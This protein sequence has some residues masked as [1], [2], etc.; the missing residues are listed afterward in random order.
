MLT[1]KQVKDVVQEQAD[2]TETMQRL[3]H[4]YYKDA[5][6]GTSNMD[7]IAFLGWWAINEKY[8]GEDEMPMTDE[9]GQ[10][11]VDPATG[12][13]QMQRVMVDPTRWPRALN[14]SEGG[15][16]DLA[17]YNKLMAQITGVWDG[18]LG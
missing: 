2:I 1:Q 13:P 9:M 4:E 17:R 18:N 16:K 12:Q 10:P 6:Y 15:K 8:H 5:G 14:N 7:N 3:I 11:M